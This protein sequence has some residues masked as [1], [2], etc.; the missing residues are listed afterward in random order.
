MAKKYDL[1]IQLLGGFA[2]SIDGK[3]IPTEQWRLKKTRSLVKLLAL[4]HGHFLHRDQILEALWPNTDPSTAAN[5]FYQ[6]LHITRKLL[7]PVSEGHLT[8]EKGIL[9]LSPENDI[10]IDI[11]QFEQAAAQ[12]LGLATETSHAMALASQDPLNFQ[13]ALSFYRGE[14]LPEDRYEEWARERRER[15]H[16][17]YLRLLLELARLHENRGEFTIGIETYKRALAEDRANEDAHLGLMRLYGLSGKRQQALRQFQLLKEGL[18]EELEAEPGLAA[19]Q[20]YEAIQSGQ[21]QTTTAA[22]PRDSSTLS[23]PGQ[24]PNNLPIPV[25]SFIGREAEVAEVVHLLERHRLVTLH[26]SGGTGKTRLALEVAPRLLAQYPAGAWLVEMAPLTNPEGVPQKVAT[27]LG[28]Q[29]TGEISYPELLVN[30]LRERRLLLILDNCE[31]LLEGC[32]RLADILLRGCSK[33]TILTTSR[34]VMGISG[35][36]TYRVPSLAA[37]DPTW[38]S[39][40]ELGQC[41]AVQ[42][43]MQRAQAVLPAFQLTEH[44]IPIVA[45]LCHRLD[46]IPLAIELAAVRVNVLS[47]EQIAARLDDRFRFLTGGSRTALPRQRTLRGSI[48]WSYNLLPETERLLLQRLSVF[49]GGWTLEAAE[50]VCAFNGLDIWDILEGLAAL[51]NKSLVVSN[52]ST[53]AEVRYRILETIR[54]YAQEKLDESDQAATVRGRHMNYFLGLAEVYGPLLRTPQ[55]AELLNRLDLELDNLRG[56]LGWALSRE[57]LSWSE[58]AVRIVYTLQYFWFARMLVREV[59]DWIESALPP[60]TGNDPMVTNLRAKAYFISGFVQEINWINVNKGKAYLEESIRLFHHIGNI[61]GEALAYA[62][63]S[64]LLAQVMKFER[65]NRKQEVPFQA[66]IEDYTHASQTCREIV[67]GLL[68]MRDP[69]S[70]WIVASSLFYSG[71]GAYFLKDYEIARSSLQQARSI[72]IELGD[73]MGEINTANGQALLMMSRSAEESQAVLRDLE[74]AI[75]FAKLMNVRFLLPMLLEEC[76]LACYDLG[77]FQEMV[78]YYTEARSMYHET[79]N[80]WDEIFPARMRGLG[81][82]H[83]GNSPQARACLLECLDLSFE[84]GDTQTIYACLIFLAGIASINDAAIH[85][86]KLLGFV[87][88]TSGEPGTMNAVWEVLDRRDKT[89][90]N[91]ILSQTKQVIPA[92]EFDAFWQ[93]GREMTMEQALEEARNP[94]FDP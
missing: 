83:L 75:E 48:D 62:S 84:L 52:A 10:S 69:E 26:G 16:Q 56:A 33:L 92:A 44:T 93:Q 40:K 13:V 4:A 77:R 12:I 25:T 87:E 57:T 72:F 21:F 7:R 73:W 6:M 24:V 36:V 15:L 88:R 45:H 9:Y 90:F 63:L 27:A 1:Y 41:E 65:E 2:V 29:C 49:W 55:V 60:L 64:G 51:V 61:S 82:Y 71:M 18:K 37:P 46:G 50:K 91:L 19:N 68:T 34:E 85:A 20:L 74:R 67:Q 43:F 53:G 32:A 28:L 30:Y 38:H 14:L 81:L 89:E 8:L 86:V 31:H 76:G 3:A 54:Q 47:V 11:E 5:L 78:D 66:S 42:L 80:P 59:I 79:A 35:E 23:T 94:P 17:I 39:S 22:L 70:R 58:K